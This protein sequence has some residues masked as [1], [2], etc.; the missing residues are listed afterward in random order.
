MADDNIYQDLKDVLEEFKTFLAQEPRFGTIKTAISSL[1]SV[2]PKIV[3][4]IDLLI[5]LMNQIKTEIQNLD[6]SAIPGL[7]DVSEFTGQITSFL[8][9][10]ADL[11]SDE[12][13]GTVDDIR[14]A[15]NLVGGLPSLEEVKA[16]IVELIGFI[17][18]KLGELKPA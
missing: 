5:D 9:A 10:A 11:V 2:I 15:I 1:A 3:D 8:D 14:S 12:I 13:K 6:V 18:G 7:S 17:V 16:D 4:V